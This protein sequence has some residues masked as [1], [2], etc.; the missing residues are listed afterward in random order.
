MRVTRRV[1]L[2]GI[3]AIA[4]F[5]ILVISLAL[6]DLAIGSSAAAAQTKEYKYDAASVLT[7]T[8]VAFPLVVKAGQRHLEETAARPFLSRGIRL[9]D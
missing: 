6:S 8:A 5:L 2:S 4:L 3:A 7:E 9:G 1:S